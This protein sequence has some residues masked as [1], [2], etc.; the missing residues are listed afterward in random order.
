MLNNLIRIDYSGK[1]DR[2]FEIS[3]TSLSPELYETY[4]TSTIELDYRDANTNSFAVAQNHPNPWKSNTSINVFLPEAGNVN[5][6]VFNAQG[7]LVLSK[8]VFFDAGSN[9]INM[10]ANELAGSGVYH[11]KLSSGKSSVTKRFLLIE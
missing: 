5:M 10:N 7:Q 11:Y 4:E 8:T 3:N 1:S 6:E 9:V 2:P